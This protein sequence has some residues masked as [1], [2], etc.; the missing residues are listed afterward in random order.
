MAGVGCGGTAVVQVRNDQCLGDGSRVT[1]LRVG[2]GQTR[3][4]GNM[5]G[6]GLGRRGLWAG[7][8]FGPAELGV[9]VHLRDEE[10]CDWSSSGLEL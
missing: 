9:P 10:R 8:V 6:A 7:L 3:W 4:T 2:G 1:W 5:G